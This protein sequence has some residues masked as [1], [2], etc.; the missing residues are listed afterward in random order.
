MQFEDSFF[1]KVEKKTKVDKDT[2][3]HLAEKLQNGN[4]K[5]EK[6]IREVI[7]TLSKMT[8]K[9]VSKEREDKIIETIV[10]DKVPKSIDKMF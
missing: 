5:D 8:G 1:K 10:E 4:M 9:P 6:T 7:A 3:V 2:I